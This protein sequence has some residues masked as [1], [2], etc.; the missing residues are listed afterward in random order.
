MIYIYIILAMSQQQI[1]GW[2]ANTLSG[3]GA[4]LSSPWYWLLF[5]CSNTGSKKSA[6]ISPSA[7]SVLTDHIFKVYLVS[8]AC[9]RSRQ[10]FQSRVLS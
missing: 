10:Q 9:S 8:Q 3:R 5:S 1:E 2:K 7:V 4:A 6:L